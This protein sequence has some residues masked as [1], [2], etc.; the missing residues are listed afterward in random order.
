MHGVLFFGSLSSVAELPL[1]ACYRF[2]CLYTEARMLCYY[3]GLESSSRWV[4][5]VIVETDDRNQSS[6][7]GSSIR[8][9]REEDTA[10][11]HPTVLLGL[12]LLD[13]IDSQNKPISPT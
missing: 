5:G 2:C 13:S 1:P 9:T 7:L 10:T 6:I 8:K 12:A 3:V 4:K 11:V